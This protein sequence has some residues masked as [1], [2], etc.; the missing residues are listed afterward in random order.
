MTQGQAPSAAAT[1]RF[2]MLRVVESMVGLKRTRIYKLI[3]ESDFPAPYKPGGG[4][5][6]RF[7]LG[8]SGSRKRARR[9]TEDGEL[10]E[11]L[12]PP[13]PDGRRGA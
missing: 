7:W 9:E 10:P 13:R 11:A 2:V 4:A 3:R 6:P 8:W 5:K 12:D 1:D